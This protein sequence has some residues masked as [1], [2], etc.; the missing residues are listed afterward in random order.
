[1]VAHTYDPR[2]FRAEEQITLNS[3]PVLLM[4]GF[5]DYA[6]AHTHTHTHV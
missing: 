2:T 3:R 1:M 5:P 6:C 4:Y